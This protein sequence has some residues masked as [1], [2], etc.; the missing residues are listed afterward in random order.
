MA[1]RSDLSIPCVTSSAVELAENPD[2]PFLLNNHIFD[3]CIPFNFPAKV[4]LQLRRA[5]WV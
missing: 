4:I 3:L 1:V 5:V 2:A